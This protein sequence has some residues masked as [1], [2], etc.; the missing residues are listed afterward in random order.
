MGLLAD[1]LEGP[2]QGPPTSTGVCD[3]RGMVDAHQALDQ[4]GGDAT[5][6]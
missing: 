2:P 6:P 3:P 4:V 1:P 5:G